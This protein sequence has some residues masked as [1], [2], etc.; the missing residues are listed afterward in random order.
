[1]N[2]WQNGMRNNNFRKSPITNYLHDE[3]YTI[4]ACLRETC[5]KARG[6][7]L[8]FEVFKYFIRHHLKNSLPINSIT[9]SLYTIG[10]QRKI[11]SILQLVLNIDQ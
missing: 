6:F 8:L 2:G 10:I 11:V 5:N 9:L 7:Y 1:M 3:T 4:T